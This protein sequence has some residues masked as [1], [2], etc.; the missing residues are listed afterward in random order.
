M[1]NNKTPATPLPSTHEEG[2]FTYLPK[3]LAIGLETSVGDDAQIIM[4]TG[5]HICTIERS[6]SLEIA[7][8]IIKRYNEFENMYLALKECREWYEN[9]AS[10]IAPETPI[11]F[12]KA[13]SALKNRKPYNL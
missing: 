13:L 1:K 9:N 3:L 2:K 5:E 4:E 10:K 12:S 7:Q 8:E 6:P 11:C